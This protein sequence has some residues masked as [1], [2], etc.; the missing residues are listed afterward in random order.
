MFQGAAALV[1][2][3]VE[4]WPDAER[5]LIPLSRVISPLSRM[6]GESG[7]LACA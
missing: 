7:Y 6:W 3:F 1:G 5:T 2:H 4:V